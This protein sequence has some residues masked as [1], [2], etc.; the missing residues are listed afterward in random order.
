M[1]QAQHKTE[2][3]LKNT[4][5]TLN[6][7][8]TK[9][10]YTKIIGLDVLGEFQNK[11]GYDGIFLGKKDQNWLLEFTVSK[12]FPYH[13]FDEDDLLIFYPDNTQE[14]EAILNNIKTNNVIKWEPKNPY[15]KEYGIMIKDPDGYGIII[16]K[17]LSNEFKSLWT[18]E[19][20]SDTTSS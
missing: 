13:D 7:N 8:K 20:R 1:K 2:M 3:K 14:Y 19:T 15:W 6:L 9:E 5:H 10:F 4:R 18:Y 17:I 12:N 11:E 16:K